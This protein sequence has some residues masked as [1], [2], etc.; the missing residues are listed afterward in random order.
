MFIWIFV[1]LN[2]SSF[3]FIRLIFRSRYASRSRRFC[4]SWLQSVSR[5]SALLAVMTAL[6]AATIQ[7]MRL[8]TRLELTD[9]AKIAQMKMT[10]LT[11][12]ERKIPRNSGSFQKH[13][14]SAS[15]FFSTSCSLIEWPPMCC[16]WKKRFLVEATKKRK[17]FFSVNF[18]CL[19]KKTCTKTS[20]RAFFEYS[21]KTSLFTSLQNKGFFSSGKKG[22]CRERLYKEMATQKIKW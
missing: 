17:N 16:W 5:L 20:R 15:Y 11:R 2:K 12:N 21:L 1:H 13:L 9:V 3:N 6:L 4:S 10:V 19:R 18:D 14:G 22:R 8:N 7:P